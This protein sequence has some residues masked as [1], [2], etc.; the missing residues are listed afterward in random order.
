V[1]KRR[2]LVG[3]CVA[4]IIGLGIYLFLPETG[5]LIWHLR[6]GS[7]VRLDELQ[8]QVPAFYSAKA[9]SDKRVLYINAVPGRARTFFKGDRILKVSVISVHQ[10]PS[11]EIG[12]TP[13]GNDDPLASHEYK[14]IIDRQLRLGGSTGRCVGFTGPAIW[15]GDEDVEISCKFQDGFEAHF[16]GTEPGVD[17]FYKLLTTAVRKKEGL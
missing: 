7:S 17:D 4:V 10:L 5:A 6:H 11:G 2:L 16:A 1:K 13:S 8:F 3:L 14:K 15:N 9:H 12:Q